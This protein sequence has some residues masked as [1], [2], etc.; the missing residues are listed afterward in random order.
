MLKN[1][2]FSFFALLVLPLLPLQ[3]QDKEASG[4]KV[5]ALLLVPGGPTIE[6]YAIAAETGKATGP[7]V[8]GARGISDPLYPGARL[9][10]LAIPDTSTESGHRPVAEV[11]LPNSGGD[12]IVLLEPEGNRFKPHLVSG[13]AARFGNS[14]TMFFNATDHPI[15]ASLGES[16]ILIPPRKPVVAE[17]PP[18]GE[19][20]WYQVAFYE[21]QEDGSPRVFSNTRWPYRN[22]SRSYVF[23]YR[24]EPSGRISY[25]AVDETL[26]PAG[27]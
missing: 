18:R 8:V 13:R 17:A 7:V 25:Q 6:L 16:R 21:P 15:G 23:F 5:R 1:P 26:Q 12:F 3:A 27:D 24:S 10:S 22:A 11:S 4:V 19:Q 9:F 2:F 14:S 20:P